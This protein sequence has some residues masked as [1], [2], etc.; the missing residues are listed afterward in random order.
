MNRGLRLFTPAIPA[1]VAVGFFVSFANWIPQTHWAP[2]KKLALTADLTPAELARAGATIVRERG[3]MACH[4][5]EPGAGVKG[6]GRG[7]N[8]DGIAARRAQGAAGAPANV[9]DY[10]VQ[11]LYEPG[12]HLVEGYPNIMPPAIGAPAKL[13]YEEVTAV[14]NYLQ[15]LGG[16]AS[17]KLGELPKPPGSGA[18]APIQAAAAPAVPAAAGGAQL[19]TDLGCVA[20]HAQSP[21]PQAIGPVFDADSIRKTAGERGM[22]PE[23]YLMESIVEPAAYQRE[24]FPAGLMPA[25]YGTKLTAAQLESIVAYLLGEAGS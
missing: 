8:L 3:C 19:L 12:A 5:M 15:S 22:S 2:P 7:P 20:C 10:L 24:G 4:T 1:V 25:D 17:V 21:G 9:V 23:A 11:S 13:S 18:A 6:G 14:V 16:T